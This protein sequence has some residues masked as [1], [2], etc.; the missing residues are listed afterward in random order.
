MNIYTYIII[1]AFLLSMAIGFISI[2]IIFNF[3]KK[4]ALYDIPNSRKVHKNKI[5]RLGGIAF[6]P[7]ML[8]SFFMAIGTLSII[9][10]EQK[11][12][13]NLWTVTFM[14]SLMLIYSIGLI[15]DILGLS[16]R[17]KFIIQLIAACSLP[18]SGLYIN[19]M[20]GLFGIH[21]IPF[22][23]GAPI[24]VLAITFIDNAINLIDGIDGLAGGLAIIALAG[25]FI[26]FCNIE[27]WV[28]CI[29]IAGL[30]GVIVPFLYYNVTGGPKHRQK[31]FMGD[32]GSLTLG[33]ILG[34]LLVKYSMN[35]TALLEYRPYSLM[36]TASLIIVPTFD[37]FRVMLHRVRN[38]RAIFSADKCHIH[39][40]LLRYGLSQ[41]A[42]LAV[43]LALAVFYIIINNL[44]Q[45]A[46]FTCILIFDILLYTAFHLALNRMIK[47]RINKE[48]AK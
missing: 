17:T 29:L 40:K 37:V 23:I 24:T 47:N 39:H 1:G 18:L 5:P 46:G 3:C 32:S 21:E 9:V 38:H 43:I 19:N 44:L 20:Y 10:S 15:D 11:V 35:N 42:T 31:I 36:Q 7:G 26:L 22:W 2:P 30:I 45:F 12:S 27:L 34:F 28:H 14:I 25:F 8:F 6:M 41:R 4:K 48:R 33:F 16:P 13:V